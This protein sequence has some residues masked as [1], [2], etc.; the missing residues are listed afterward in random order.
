MT[1]TKKTAADTKIEKL[2]AELALVKTDLELYKSFMHIVR[3]KGRN[4]KAVG[5]ALFSLLRRYQ[6]QLKEEASRVK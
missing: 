4:E 3:Q 1:T 5:E 2:E 6:K